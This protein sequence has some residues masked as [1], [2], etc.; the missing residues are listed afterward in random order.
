MTGRAVVAVTLLNCFCVFSCRRHGI[1]VDVVVSRPDQRIDVE[2]IEAAVA[3]ATRDGALAFLHSQMHGGRLRREPAGQ[4]SRSKRLAVSPASFRLAAETKVAG[5]AGPA[6][7]PRTRP[8]GAASSRAFK[9]AEVA[10]RE[11]RA[12]PQASRA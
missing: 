11:S 3:D 2:G 7:I 10:T 12:R 6:A 5:A 9:R 8:I 4:R 1:L